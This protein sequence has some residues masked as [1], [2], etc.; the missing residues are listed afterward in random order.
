MP[1]EKLYIAYGSNLNLRQMAHRCPTAAPLTGAKLPGYDLKFRGRDGWAVATVEPGEGSVPVLLWRI[2]PRD[3][4]SL[5]A[6]EGW[7]HFYRKENVDIEVGGHT[8]SAMVYIMNDGHPLG[9]P[10]QSYLETILEGYE[11]AGFDPDALRRALELSGPEQTQ[12]IEQPG[13]MDMGW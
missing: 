8:V 9:M 13:Q 10:S 12:E 5:D 6:Y 2:K 3:E 4:R 11:S 1:K 7:P